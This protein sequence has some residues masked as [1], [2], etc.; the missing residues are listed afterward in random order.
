MLPFKRGF[1]FI[2]IYLVKTM[3]HG[4][5]HVVVDIGEILIVQIEFHGTSVTWLQFHLGEFAQLFQKFRRLAYC[6]RMGEYL[7]HL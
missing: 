5:I 1:Q 3:I 7:P 2:D 6:L 4:D